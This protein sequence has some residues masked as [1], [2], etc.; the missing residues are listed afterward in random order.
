M[1]I[2]RMLLVIAVTAFPLAACE[3]EGPMER[4]GEEMDE[5]ARDVGNAVE[6]ACEDAKKGVD[7]ADPD[8]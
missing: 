1:S 3:P 6:D 4:A 2:L 7:A 8:C 5:A